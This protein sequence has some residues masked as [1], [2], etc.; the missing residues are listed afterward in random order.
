MKNEE[1]LKLEKLDSDCHKWRI[2]V[3]DL[4]RKKE[5]EE[6][7]KSFQCY[8]DKVKQMNELREVMFSKFD[9]RGKWNSLDYCYS[10]ELGNNVAELIRGMTIHLNHSSNF[11]QSVSWELKDC[12]SL[13]EF[14]GKF[15]LYYENE[16]FLNS[17][18]IDMLLSDS[19]I[20]DRIKIRN[21]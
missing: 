13:E 9:G 20:E 2:R 18:G 3:E 10:H 15:K 1:E 17:K 6:S 11:E 21:R 12:K 4:L 14:K 8:V 7:I 16:E 5:Y 19:E